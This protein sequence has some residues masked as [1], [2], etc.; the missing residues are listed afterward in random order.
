MFVS[1]QLLLGISLVVFILISLYPG[2]PPANLFGR[3]DQ[4]WRSGQDLADVQS[5]FGGGTPG[6][7][8][9]L[10]WMKETLTGNLGFSSLSPRP[11][12]EII[13]EALP[14]TLGLAA[15]ALAV[16]SIVGISIGLTWAKYQRS[17][18]IRS[19][20]AIPIVLSSIPSVFLALWGIYVFAILLGWLPVF[21]LWTPGADKSFD[22]DLVRHAILPTAALALPFI[23]IYMRYAQQSMVHSPTEETEQTES[24]ISLSQVPLRSRSTLRSVAVPLVR[25]LSLSLPPLIGSALV[26]EILFSL[27][28]LGQVGY[29]SLLRRDY[30]VLTA[31]LLAAAVIALAARLLSDVIHGWL[32]PSV[33]GS[34]RGTAPAPSEPTT[35]SRDA[36]ARQIGPPLELIDRPL[37]HRPWNTARRRFLSHRPAVAGLI[38]LIGFVAVAVLGPLVAPYS[39]HETLPLKTMAEP[40]ASHW[41]GT[42]RFGRDVFSL[43]LHGA[44]TSLWVGVMAVVISLV[45]GFAIGG[46]AGRFGGRIDSVL[47]RIT[48]V[49]MTFPP[50]FLML[51]LVIPTFTVIGPSSVVGLMIG[52]VSWPGFARLIRRQ[53]LVQRHAAETADALA[54]ESD[55]PPTRRRV[56]GNLAGPVAVAAAYGLAGALLTEATLSFLGFGVPLPAIS[57]GQMIGQSRGIALFA[58]PMAVAPAVL[59]VLLVLSV[60]L[61]GDGLR[62]AYDARRRRSDAV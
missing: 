17:I 6:P 31:S 39:P 10:F 14:V 54:T 11:V 34:T 53:V 19:V 60:H 30:P 5:R 44:R 22:L 33:R 46:P 55:R 2:D 32:D 45:V 24:A 41:L 59:I 52:L 7:V 42:D 37:E 51:F 43:L 58:S 48:D 27:G 29:T 49:V 16:A 38:I 56:G 47:M 35:A 20:G 4:V 21:G 62:D 8:R 9:Y 26:V 61:V 28:G 3:Y 1:V 36:A 23:A 50:L 13:G 15:V 40:S 57:W 18:L 12:A 25:N